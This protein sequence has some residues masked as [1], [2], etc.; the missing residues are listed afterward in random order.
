MREAECQTCPLFGRGVCSQRGSLS[1][2]LCSEAPLLSSHSRVMSTFTAEH[3]QNHT[4]SL[5]PITRFTWTSRFHP[6]H[7]R[8]SGREHRKTSTR[9]KS[10]TSDLSGEC[11]DFTSESGDGERSGNFS[12]SSSNIKEGGLSPYHWEQALN[13][14][15]KWEQHI[16]LFS[17]SEAWY[18]MV[19][20]LIFSPSI[21]DQRPGETSASTFQ[22]L[23]LT[24][25]TEAR[26]R[27]KSLWFGSRPRMLGPATTS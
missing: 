4:T 10:L 17:A 7:P 21:K 24:V 16:L 2:V 12:Y 25:E 5:R 18:G 19:G 3:P 6:A 15:L 23:L 26:L 20:S 22:L 11:M 27:C 9:L 13:P 8:T 14:Y 1:A